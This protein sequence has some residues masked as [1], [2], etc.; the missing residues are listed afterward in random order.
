MKQIIRIFTVEQ[1]LLI[2][3]LPRLRCIW[4]QKRR[5]PKDKL[6]LTEWFQRWLLWLHHWKNIKIFHFLLFVLN[7]LLFF[8]CPQRIWYRTIAW[9]MSDLQI[10]LG[11][12]FWFVVAWKGVTSVCRLKLSSSQVSL[13][14]IST[15]KHTSAITYLSEYLVTVPTR[16]DDR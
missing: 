14:K 4:N 3:I 1:F 6:T 10:E 15:I 2:L 9:V 5:T 16:Y 8:R 7:I 12:E 11:F 13:S